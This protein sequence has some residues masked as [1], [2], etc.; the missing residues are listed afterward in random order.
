[1]SISKSAK[2]EGLASL[3]DLSKELG[4]GKTKLN[5][6]YSMGLIRPKGTVSQTMVFDR[7][8]IK[9]IM[10]EIEK[11]SKTGKTLRQIADEFAKKRK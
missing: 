1:M 10:K 4:C 8:E 5:F 2:V 7:Q 6:Y 11:Q 9:D 3:S